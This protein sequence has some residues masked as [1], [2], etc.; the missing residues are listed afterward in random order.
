V[1]FSPIPAPGFSRVHRMF[2]RPWPDAQR[3]QE[4]GLVR[5][6]TSPARHAGGDDAAAP[7]L[8]TMAST[9]SGTSAVVTLAASAAHAAPSPKAFASVTRTRKAPARRPTLSASEE[10][11]SALSRVRTY[12]PNGEL[13]ARI[14]RRRRPAVRDARGLPAR[15]A[16][17]PRAS[18]RGRRRTAP[19]CAARTHPPALRPPA[20]AT[21]LD[22]GSDGRRSYTA[23][24]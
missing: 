4:P 12:Y 14:W 11:G 23:C 18:P 13:S 24:V 17:P 6:W 15:A 8:L 10:P 2:L 3:R 21:E 5:L 7:A 9:V 20:K 19:R 1:T 16:R 22:V